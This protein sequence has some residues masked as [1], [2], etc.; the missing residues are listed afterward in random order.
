VGDE[1]RIGIGDFK[2]F[3]LLEGG[4]WEAL[5]TKEPGLI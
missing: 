2:T 5:A 3:L 4:G 1:G